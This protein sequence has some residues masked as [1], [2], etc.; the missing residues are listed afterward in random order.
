MPAVVATYM[1]VPSD[2]VARIVS[3]V[4][5]EKLTK[6]V[7]VPE[8]V[9]LYIAVTGLNVMLAP[10]VTLP[11]VAAE[12]VILPVVTVD[13]VVPEVIPVAFA[14]YPATMPAVLA[15]VI[16]VALV[17]AEAAV[18]VAIAGAKSVATRKATPALLA[19]VSILHLPVKARTSVLLLI[20][21]ISPGVHTSMP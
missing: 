14:T 11:V 16:V 1:Y 3:L 5:D 2:V 12:I 8:L 15:T 4:N 21:L 10:L 19:P 18:V 7:D 17:A 20:R 6:A 9:I 13:T